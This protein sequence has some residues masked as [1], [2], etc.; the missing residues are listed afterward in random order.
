M[1]NYAHNVLGTVAIC[2]TFLNFPLSSF[3]QNNTITEGGGEMVFEAGECISNEQRE[4]I[5]KILD[6]QIAELRA[7][8][9]LPEIGTQKSSFIGFDWPVQKSANAPYFNVDAIS[10]FVDQN[11]GVGIL[12][13]S[14]GARSYDGHLGT[15]IFTWP[16]WW[17][18]MDHDL[19]EV[20]AG[21]PGT[22]IFKSDGNYDRQC[23]WGPGVFWNAVYVQHADGSVA[24]YG[25]L[26]NGSLTSKPVGA[27][28]VS[29]EYLGVVGSSG[30]STGPHLHL[31]IHDAA[32]NI[33]DP[34]TGACNSLNPT[35]WWNNQEPYYNSQVNALSTHSSPPF[36]PACPTTELP[37][38]SNVFYQ[39]STAYF[40][41]YFRD[42]TTGS[43]HTNRIY[44]GD[45]SLFN[46]WT[47]PFTATYSASW[48][49]NSYYL[50]IFAVPGIWRF[51]TD[52]LGKTYSHYF[53][54]C[55]SPANCPCYAPIALN[56]SNITSTSAT[57]SW[58]GDPESVGFQ[59]R[60]GAVGGP[61][62]T[63]ITYNDT[64]DINV[65]S[66]GTTY[67]W[68]VR[69][70][71]TDGSISPWSTSH[72]F[73][74]PTL[75]QAPRTEQ[76][77]YY[78][79]PTSDL[80]YFENGPLDLVSVYELNG[81]KVLGQKQ[82]SSIDLSQLESG[83]YLLEMRKADSIQRGKLVVE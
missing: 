28:V 57:F 47:H 17:Y 59:M 12:D 1:K 21:A 34:Y 79:N 65:L 3:A 33:I 42:Q 15:D 20:V 40:V 35:S 76:I 74:T 69:A 38:Y 68:E 2:L 83:I 82:V 30:Y 10:N 66:P 11:T 63:K 37:Y 44:M 67:S 58:Q 56:V 53:K 23:S 75:H 73:S 64:Q 51:E 61:T 55:V 80:V 41:R 22:I 46:V 31:E 24:W 4:E 54:V 62:G 8:G 50:N 32:G 70:M 78:P 48:W 77:E 7:K 25:H 13:Y 39:N 71:C 14:C 16:F 6:E 36:F 9:I 27:T 29:G 72:T 60:G 81:K 19:A 49:W 5:Q 26:K 18:N 52:Y 45:G 43:S